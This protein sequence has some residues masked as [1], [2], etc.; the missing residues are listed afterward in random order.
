L[1]QQNKSDIKLELHDMYFT[2]KPN[3]MCKGTH[4]LFVSILNDNI[5]TILNGKYEFC[6]QYTSR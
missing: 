2:L 5:R 3:F 4:F 6:Y 1:L